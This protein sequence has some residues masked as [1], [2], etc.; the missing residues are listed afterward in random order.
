MNLKIASASDY[1]EL[2]DV[3][4]EIYN[5]VSDKAQFNWSLENIQAELLI[6]QFLVYKDEN[7]QIQ[8]FISFRESD[9]EIEI[10]ALG[11]L[12]TAR[13]Q[14]VMAELIHFLQDYSRKASKPLL[15][16]VHHKN[17]SAINLYVKSGFKQIGRRKEYYSD[18]E[19]ALTFRFN[20][21]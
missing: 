12:P 7:E 11:T 17:L 14:S 10:M 19:D 16:E 5:S 13:R 21:L 3:F 2:T 9:S 8:G 6:S 15:L 1:N 4:F 18:H 20:E